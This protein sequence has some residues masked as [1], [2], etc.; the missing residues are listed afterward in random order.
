MGSYDETPMREDNA[1]HGRRAKT[2]ERRGNPVLLEET[3]GW[4]QIFYSYIISGRIEILDP[5]IEDWIG[6]W[7][8]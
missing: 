1:A 7:L 2:A 3:Y 6:K 5:K 4:T 8:M